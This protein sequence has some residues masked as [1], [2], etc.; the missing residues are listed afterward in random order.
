MK[1]YHC[2]R[3]S[4]GCHVY[5][6]HE[7]PKLLIEVPYPLPNRLD[8][9]NDNPCGFEWG[10]PTRAGAQFSRSLLADLTGDDKFAVTWHQAFHFQFVAQ[11]PREAETLQ[12]LAL[13]QALSRICF[14]PDR[15]PRLATMRAAELGINFRGK[16]G[17][18]ILREN[19]RAV[20]GVRKRVSRKK[21]VLDRNELNS[22]L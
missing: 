13:W 17:D 19:W 7:E 1:L 8:L 16:A 18:S 15:V 6:S 10:S 11:M 14:D 20:C 22:L 3:T 5:V 2:S 9:S 4:T 21:D 12:E